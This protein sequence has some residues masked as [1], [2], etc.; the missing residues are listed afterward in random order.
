[1]NTAGLSQMSTRGTSNP[2]GD[3]YRLSLVARLLLAASLIVGLGVA[4]VTIASQPAFG[5]PNLV[6][7]TTGS[8][9]GNCLVT[10][11]HTLGYAISQ[12]AA[13]DTITID[14]GTYLQSNNP[15]G[16][17][18]VVGAALL[19]SQ[20]SPRAGTPPIPSSTQLVSSTASL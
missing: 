18:N 8:D 4:V 9:T 11:C 1:M 2:A 10:P 16:T 17:H 12:A 7:S 13:G 15:S 3:A 20:S 19:R 14:A 6:V 5:A